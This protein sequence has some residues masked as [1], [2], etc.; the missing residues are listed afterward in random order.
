MG[1]TCYMVRPTARFHVLASVNNGALVMRSSQHKCPSFGITGRGSLHAY[2]QSPIK[3]APPTG[4]RVGSARAIWTW[5]WVPCRRRA[6]MAHREEERGDELRQKDRPGRL[7]EP[8]GPVSDGPLSVVVSRLL[9]DGLAEAKATRHHSGLKLRAFRGGDV[10]GDCDQDVAPLHA[11]TP[12]RAMRDSR[13]APKPWTT[14]SSCQVRL[15]A[16]SKAVRSCI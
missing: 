2:R 9:M 3:R 5:W 6:A 1:I 4:A 14:A 11:L 16:N 15:T 13:T 8:H 12:F 7:S 10:E